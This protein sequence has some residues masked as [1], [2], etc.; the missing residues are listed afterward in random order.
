MRLRGTGMTIEGVEGRSPPLPF[1]TVNDAEGAVLLSL[2]PKNAVEVEGDVISELAALGESTPKPFALPIEPVAVVGIADGDQV[3]IV[4][5]DAIVPAVVDGAESAPTGDPEI[6]PEPEDG[7]NESATREQ[8]IADAIDLLGDN[9]FVM[10]GLRK[11]KPKVDAVNDIVG[12]DADVTAGEID[13][14]FANREAGE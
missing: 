1:V 5:D 2:Y 14:V 7:G 10:T 3:G 13:A 4:D 11:G 9:D 8:A 12:D 6:T